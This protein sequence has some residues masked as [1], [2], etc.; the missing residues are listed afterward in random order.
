LLFI[1]VVYAVIFGS[2]YTLGPEKSTG[3]ILIIELIVLLLIPVAIHGGLRFRAAKSSW[4]NIFFG[5]RGILKEF[6]ILFYKNILLTIVT[7]GIYGSWMTANIQKYIYGHLRFGNVTFGYCGLGSD[8]F[9]INIKGLLL[10]IFTLGIYS[11]WWSAEILNY[12]FENTYLVQNNNEIRLN[13]KFRGGD[14]F[15]FMVVNYLIILFT[16]GLGYPWVLKRSL[17]LYF[18]N[19]ETDPGFDPN[20]IVQTEADYKDASGE[21]FFRCF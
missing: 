3:V 14:L 17:D 2:I 13:A 15:G 18:R 11:F 6:V 1:V 19:I 12:D 16:L 20:A 10:T 5:Y 9:K 4:R 7:L 21:D 8:R